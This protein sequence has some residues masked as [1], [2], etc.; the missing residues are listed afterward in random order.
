MKDKYDVTNASTAK[1]EAEKATAELFR[2]NPGR[3]EIIFPPKHPYY[4][5]H[6]NG[7][8]LNLSGLIGF[9]D[10]LLDAESDRCKAKKVV[11]ELAKIKFNIIEENKKVAASRVAT[12]EKWN[13]IIP[14]NKYHLLKSD[15]QHANKIILTR[16]SIKGLTAKFH[17]S[18]PARD[19]FIQNLE[20]EISKAKYVGWAEDEIIDGK[21]KH[22][23]TE[24][25]QYYKITLGGKQSFITAKKTKDGF[26]KP[27]SIETNNEFKNIRGV[28]NE[29]PPR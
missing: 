27:Y 2:F 4:P 20:S 7:E 5:Q 23:D 16:R 25:W 8:K 13:E 21:Q 11:E 19:L 6:C 24:L 1:R 10:W 29:K 26:Y 9:A 17:D 28:K 18:A 12:R 22:P 15:L 14:K 3:E